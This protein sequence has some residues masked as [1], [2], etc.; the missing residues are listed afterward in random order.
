MN[1]TKNNDTISRRRFAKDLS[2]AAV[3]TAGLLSSGLSI[4]A[5]AAPAGPKKRPL[6]RTG[7]MVSEISLGGHIDGPEAAKKNAT[8]QDVRTSVIKRAY[9]LGINYFDMNNTPVEHQTMGVALETLGIRDKIYLVEA[10]KNLYKTREETTSKILEQV[11]NNLKILRTSYA[12]VLRFTSTTPTYDPDLIRGFVDAG[13]ELKRQG[14]VRHLALAS[15][16]PEYLKHVLNDFPEIEVI[17]TPYNF[18]VRKAAEEAFP[19]AKAKGVGVVCIKPF[20]KATMF[21]LKGGLQQEVAQAAIDGGH[22]IEELPRPQGQSVALAN[23]RWIL[24]NPDIT[25]A[26]PG[27]E[28]PSEVEENVS[29]SAG[30]LTTADLRLLQKHVVFTLPGP[31]YAWLHEWRTA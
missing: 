16:R 4:A 9:E 10:C 11:P 24:S 5:A 7:M 25:C 22:K 20:L 13:Q 18:L 31:D 30:P 21:G 6:G 28:L 12:D 3:G 8:A 19:M 14:K 26:V 23:L 15:H 29:A 17:Y 27:M 1:E 2:L